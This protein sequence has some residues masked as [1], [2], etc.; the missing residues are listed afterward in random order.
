MAFHNVKLIALYVTFFTV[1]HFGEALLNFM[2][3]K[4]WQEKQVP[5]GALASIE[6]LAAI[7]HKDYIL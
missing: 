1:I 2:K 4:D 5:L 6:R 7:H 3:K